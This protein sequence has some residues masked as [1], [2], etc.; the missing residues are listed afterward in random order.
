MINL[1]LYLMIIFAYTVYHFPIHSKLKTSIRNI[2]N[3]LSAEGLY[4]TLDF[5]YRNKGKLVDGK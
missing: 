5:V 2:K 1:F 3:G 4:H